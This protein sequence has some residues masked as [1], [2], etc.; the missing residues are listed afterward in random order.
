MIAFRTRSRRLFVGTAVR[1]ERFRGTIAMLNC[2]MSKL[3]RQRT[4]AVCLI[5]LTSISPAWAQD[6][7]AANVPQESSP[8]AVQPETIEEYFRSALLM[9]R[10]ARPQLAKSYLEQLQALNPTDDDML[11]LRAEFGT[12]SFVLLR[13]VE[14][15]EPVAGQLLDRLNEA[16]RNRANEPGFVEGVIRELGG[17]ARQRATAMDEL[18]H[19]GPLAVPPILKNLD[20]QLGV[21]QETLAV[22]LMRLGTDAIAPLIGALE[23]PEPAVQSVSIKVLGMVGSEDEAI[24]LLAPAFAEKSPEGVQVLARRALAQIRFDDAELAYRILSDGAAKKLLDRATAYLNDTYIWPEMITEQVDVPVWTWDADAGTVV[25]HRTSRRHAAIYLAER[26]ARESAEVAPMREEPAVVVLAALLERTAEDTNWAPSLP[27]GPGTSHDLAVRSGP[28]VGTK[29]LQFALDNQL[30]GTATGIL[31]ALAENGSTSLLQGT[32]STSPMTAALN[33]PSQRVQFQAA[34]TILQW[35]PT[36]PFRGSRR[37][38]EILARALNAESRPAGVVMDPNANRGQATAVLF[39]DL[40]FQPTLVTTG[41]DGF[42]AIANQGNVELAVVHPNVIRWELTQTLANLRADART[43]SVPVIIFGPKE[44]RGTLEQHS[45]DFRRVAFINDVNSAADVYRELQPVLAQLSPPP[46][47]QAQRAGQIKDA[48]YWL[49]NLATRN[50]GD[51]FDLSIAEDAL[52]RGTSNPAVARDCIIALT[53]IGRDSVQTELLMLATAPALSDDLRELAAMQ[54]AFHIR[55]FGGLLSQT[56][57]QRLSSVW[58]TESNA[59]VRTALAS[60]I[61]SLHPKAPAARDEILAS[62]MSPAPV[63][64]QTQNIQ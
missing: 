10:L 31:Q 63:S 15:L 51:V 64:S 34:M 29:V 57:A 13:N 16:A 20:G 17:S 44:I 42:E 7:P 21:D 19:L 46:L 39:A 12:S 24:W 4:G 26:L 47:T 58:E 25:E 61:G 37:V 6:E 30:V 33:S 11:A 41:K 52:I 59:A 18:R 32:A 53:G 27:T 54:L 22:T 5:L 8:L 48:A 3:S 35:E 60:V 62:P 45:R 1:I 2:A 9:V 49:R 43:A 38:V 55:K 40:G 36:Q 23:S 14:G 50:V 56:D 28:E